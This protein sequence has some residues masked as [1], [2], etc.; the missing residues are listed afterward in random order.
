[1]FLTLPENLRLAEMFY[2][3]EDNDTVSIV[4]NKWLHAWEKSW[5]IFGAI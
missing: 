5:R 3:M 1:M 2:G 4:R